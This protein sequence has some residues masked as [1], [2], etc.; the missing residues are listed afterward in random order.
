MLHAKFVLV[1]DIVSVIGSSNMDERSFALDLE[2]SVMIVDREFRARME[3][4][5]EDFTAC[6][7]LLDV[8]AWE[9]RSL[10]RKYVENICRLTSGLL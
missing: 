10:G 8:A 2:V 5:V 3:R 4:V 1:D 7:T 6:S 9:Q